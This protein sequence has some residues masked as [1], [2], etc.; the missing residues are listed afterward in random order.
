MRNTEK[1]QVFGA[2]ALA[3]IFF[4]VSAYAAP[5]AAPLP[6][7]RPPL[8]AAHVIIFGGREAPTPARAAFCRTYPAQ[9]S[10]STDVPMQVVLTES[11]L[12]QL[13]RVNQAVNTR[14]RA[15]TDIVQHG[16][17]DRWT[18]AGPRL[19]QGDCEQY[20]SEKKRILLERGFPESALLLAVVLTS[21]G[22]GHAVLVVRTDR[23]DFVLDNLTPEIRGVEATGHRFLTANTPEAVADWRSV[24]RFA[25]PGA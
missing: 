13:N 3:G 15:V 17:E 7:Q 21:A 19:A 4:A 23:G 25:P 1:R 8:P 12:T 16:V 18:L 10:Y 11:A 5:T 14:I 2:S 20:A 22:E 24:R 6:P 9:C